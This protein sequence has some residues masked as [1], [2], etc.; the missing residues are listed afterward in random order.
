M[1]RCLV[2]SPS[3]PDDGSIEARRD[4]D[5]YRSPFGASLRRPRTTAPL[6]HTRPWDLS[7]I[8]T[9][10]SSPD[11]GSIEAALAQQQPNYS[12]H[13]PSS[14]DDGSIEAHPACTDR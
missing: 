10:P 13:S 3:S 4:P 11:D 12:R 1:R 6:K 7:K 14:P 9:S 5:K 8:L 2:P